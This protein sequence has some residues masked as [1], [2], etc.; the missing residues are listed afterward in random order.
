[1]PNEFRL[2][3]PEV[4]WRLMAGMRDVL[5]HDYEMVRLDNVWK[6]IEDI[7]ALIEPLRRLRSE[8]L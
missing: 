8:A 1:M 7:P 5:V 6:A 4:P 3:H 2:A